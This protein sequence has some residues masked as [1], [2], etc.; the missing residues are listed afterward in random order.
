MKKARSK[1]FTAIACALLVFC[2]GTAVIYASAESAKETP[3]TAEAKQPAAESGSGSVA[4]GW[5]EDE[6]GDISVS[7]LTEAE[8]LSKE[9]VE[10]LPTTVRVH[11]MTGE[12]FTKEEEEA[13]R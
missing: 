13:M 4:I 6:V 7:E 12:E 3:D 10:D 2:T 9:T 1:F 11:P 8:G 5:G